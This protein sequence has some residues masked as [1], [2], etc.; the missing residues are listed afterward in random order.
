M[1]I[2]AGAK[3]QQNTVVAMGIL[4]KAVE[5]YKEDGPYRLFYNNC[6]QYAEKFLS[7]INMNE[8]IAFR[9]DFDLRRG[10][11]NHPVHY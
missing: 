7:S 1:N 2:F 5:M 11:Y 3:T 6:Q 4:D 10:A 8:N 9:Q